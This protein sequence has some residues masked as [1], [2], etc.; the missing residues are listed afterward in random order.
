MSFTNPLDSIVGR[1]TGR[2]VRQKTREELL[3]EAKDKALARNRASRGAPSVTD[4]TRF[5]VLLLVG[6]GLAA[7]AL[8]VYL[9]VRK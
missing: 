8:A 3:G 1:G 5:P 4:A 9:W 2:R 6:L 7:A